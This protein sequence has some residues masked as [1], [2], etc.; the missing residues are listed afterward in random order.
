[1]VQ[2]NDQFYEELT[3]EKLDRILDEIAAKT[4]ASLSAPPAG[5]HAQPLAVPSPSGRPLTTKPG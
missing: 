3:I 5:P 2:I 1:M 4:K